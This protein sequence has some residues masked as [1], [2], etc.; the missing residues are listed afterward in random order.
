MVSEKLIQVDN[1]SNAFQAELAQYQAGESQQKQEL[2][3]EIQKREVLE[4]DY[5]KANSLLSN[6]MQRISKSS[7]IEEKNER[8]Q[9]QNDELSV[10]LTDSQNEC[11]FEKQKLE[12]LQIKNQELSAKILDMSLELQRLQDS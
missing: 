4:A 5:I 10:K 6:M 11:A 3:E 1:E 12:N 8:L 7:D 2:I 9:L